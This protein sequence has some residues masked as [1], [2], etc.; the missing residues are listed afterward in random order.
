MLAEEG[1]AIIFITHKL[2]EVKEVADRITVLRDGQKVGTT[3]VAEVSEVDMV[4]MM[5]GRDVELSIKKQ[6]AKR[7]A[8]VFAVQGLTCVREDGHVAVRNVS[9]EVAAGEILA[10]AGVMG[11]GQTELVETLTGLR[12]AASGTVRI[13][14][15]DL[16][17]ASPRKI[18]LYGV[19]H[20]PAD[21]MGRGVAAEAS[22]EENLISDRYFKQEFTRP[23]ILGIKRKNIKAH[24]EKLRKE[25]AIK[26]QTAVVS[27]E[28]LSGGNIQRVVVAREFT[29]NAKLMIADQPTR[30]IDVAST[31][32]VRQRLINDRDA[33]MAVLLVSADLTEVMQLADRIAVMYNGEIVAHFPTTDGVTAEELGKYM[34]GI[35]RHSDQEIVEE[36]AVL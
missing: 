24:G 7:G 18:R 21:R 28:I 33:G 12:K 20:I 19:A 15:Q 36:A 10:I 31:E 4:R 16:S 11:N 17:R 34:L 14:E 3:P 23:G 32:Y 13:H 29:A 27:V 26:A 2:K 6:P 30:G 9:F 8:E 22:I 1:K 5:V 25:F 35:K